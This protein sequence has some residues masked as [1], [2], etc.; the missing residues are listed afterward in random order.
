[1][2]CPTGDTWLALASRELNDAQ[3]AEMRAHAAGCTECE[4]E[5]AFADALNARGVDSQVNVTHFTKRVMEATVPPTQN[6]MRIIGLAAAALA[7][8]IGGGVVGYQ[9]QGE[10]VTARGSATH[11]WQERVVAEL[12]PVE[13]VVAAVV[14]K[15]TF[16]T[17][18]QWALWYRNA[19]TE[20]PLYVLAYIVDAAGVLHW[21]VPAFEVNGK[22]PLPVVLPAALAP[23]LLSEVV[24]FSEISSGEA[25]LVTVVSTVPG[26]VL[27]FE[28]AP[29]LAHEH[30][31]SLLPGSVVWRR[32]VVLAHS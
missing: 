21:L 22:E 13:S 20:R 7:T 17:E 8:L 2:N 3:G 12:R 26:S 14:Q 16:S 19:E 11:Q 18:T 24:R 32:F 9:F 15:K 5:L 28:S 30:P 6:Q 10:R 1:M 25:T 27:S 31:E 4:R 29:R 23:Q